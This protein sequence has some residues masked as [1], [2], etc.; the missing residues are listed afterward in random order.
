MVKITENLKIGTANKMLPLWK[1]VVIY[2]N[3]LKLKLSTDCWEK[4]MFEELKFLKICISDISTL[5]FNINSKCHI[6]KVFNSKC[7]FWNSSGSKDS[8]LKMILKV[9][10]VCTTTKYILGVEYL[11]FLSMTHQMLGCKIRLTIDITA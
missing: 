9:I 10:F 3:Y 5:N 1:L 6:V 2:K 4:G 11:K 7:S 8:N